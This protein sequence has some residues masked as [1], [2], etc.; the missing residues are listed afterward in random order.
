[1]GSL[2]AVA[3]ETPNE[4]QASELTVNTREERV[5]IRLYPVVVE[6]GVIE[7][8]VLVDGPLSQ[9][10]DVVEIQPLGDWRIMICPQPWQTPDRY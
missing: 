5:T 1:M 4:R 3:D 9:L 6:S 7:Q 10:T 2:L 8:S